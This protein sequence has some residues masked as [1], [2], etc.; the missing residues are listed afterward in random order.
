MPQKTA[1]VNIISENVII[2]FT[3]TPSISR[4]IEPWIKRTFPK[5]EASYYFDTIKASDDDPSHITH[6]FVLP[7]YDSSRFIAN[8]SLLRETAF[9]PADSP[10]EITQ[11]NLT[12]KIKPNDVAALAKLA[13]VIPPEWKAEVDPE[14]LL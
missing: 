13:K 3:V 8:P 6:R 10:S 4:K 5:E 2:E 1:F 11:L 12:V 9:T 7:F 14:S